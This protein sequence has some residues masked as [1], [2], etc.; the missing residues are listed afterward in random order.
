[1]PPDSS[2][3]RARR[4]EACEEHKE[5]MHQNPHW[6]LDFRPWRDFK[7]VCARTQLRPVVK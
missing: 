3:R 1:M 5:E 6:A 7:E 2:S 4:L